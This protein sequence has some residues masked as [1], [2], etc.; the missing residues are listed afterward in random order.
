MRDEGLRKLASGPACAADE[1]CVVFRA[2]IECDNVQL[3]DCGTVVH[4]D[5]LSNMAWSKVE[6][7]ICRAV[8]GSELGCSVSAACAELG[9][10]RCLHGLCTQDLAANEQAK[11]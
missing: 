4:R 2:T 9:P 3:G 1:D 5:A 8:E 6:Q 10:P 11:P 7:E